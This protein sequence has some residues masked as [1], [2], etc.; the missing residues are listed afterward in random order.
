MLF[1]HV[2]QRIRD[3]DPGLFNPCVEGLCTVARLQATPP[4]F[5][6]LFFISLTSFNPPWA[7]TIAMPI[8]RYGN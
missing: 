1:A 5:Q 6:A 8:S 3:F 2:T 7:G 4:L